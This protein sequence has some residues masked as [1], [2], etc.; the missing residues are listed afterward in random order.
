M[1][2]SRF[3]FFRP[4]RLLRYRGASFQIKQRDSDQT[5]N[6]KDNLNES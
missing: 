3:C 6:D 2:D 4:R 5:S 1:R